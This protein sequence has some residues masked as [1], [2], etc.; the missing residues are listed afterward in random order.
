MI[1]LVEQYTFGSP[2]EQQVFSFHTEIYANVVSIAKINRSKTVFKQTS[3]F[4]ELP[5]DLQQ[6][7]RRQPSLVEISSSVLPAAACVE[8]SLD[9]VTP[10]PIQA[11]ELGLK[12]Y[13]KKDGVGKQS[14]RMPRLTLPFGQDA[15]EDDVPLMPSDCIV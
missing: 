1:G 11:S 2:V 7:G 5:F 3:I 4:W 9:F 13:T 12:T 15:Q 8:V 14:T 10:K 6:S